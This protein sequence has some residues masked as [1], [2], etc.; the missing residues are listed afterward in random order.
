M[1]DEAARERLA[2]A[3]HARICGGRNTYKDRLADML[4]RV[5]KG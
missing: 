4:A 3:C 5:A 1:V 2:G